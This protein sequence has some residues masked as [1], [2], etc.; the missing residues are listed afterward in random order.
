[1]NQQNTIITNSA[2]RLY[3]A[4][5]GNVPALSAI[6]GKQCDYKGSAM[7]VAPFLYMYIQIQPSLFSSSI[8]NALNVLYFKNRKR[9]T[10]TKSSA[11]AK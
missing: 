7:K 8:V 3:F 1:M 10:L 4:R 2:S 5:V 9:Q 11:E 6:S